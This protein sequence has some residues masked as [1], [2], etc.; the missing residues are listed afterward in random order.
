MSAFCVAPVVAVLKLIYAALIRASESWRG[1]VVSP[2]ATGQLQAIGQEH[3][4]GHRR[5]HA[6]IGTKSTSVSPLSEVQ[7]RSDL[8]CQSNTYDTTP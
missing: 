1:I 7:Q 5:R 4:A 8:T 3:D 2:L 6:P